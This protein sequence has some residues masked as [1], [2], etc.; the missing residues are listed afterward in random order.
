MWGL[1]AAV[2]VRSSRPLLASPMLPYAGHC[3]CGNPRWGRRSCLPV[4]CSRP[5]PPPLATFAVP[6][7]ACAR[8]RGCVWHEAIV[9]AR[10]VGPAASR[11]RRARPRAVGTEQH[12]QTTGSQILHRTPGRSA[13]A[14]RVLPEKP[15]IRIPWPQ[16][17][18]DGNPPFAEAAQWW[19]RLLLP[20]R[21]TGRTDVGATFSRR[22]LGN[23]QNTTRLTLWLD[24]GSTDST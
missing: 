22:L 18:E 10:G 3:L 15:S 2:F 19:G 14:G 21:L 8:D 16:D 20:S 6:C 4:R 13:L 12:S 17:G 5:L 24:G 23:R 11:V 7:V 9:G 1:G